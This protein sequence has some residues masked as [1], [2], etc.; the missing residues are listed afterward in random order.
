M[1]KCQSKASFKSRSLAKPGNSM[2]GHGCLRS[3]AARVCFNPQAWR[4]AEVQR[5][6]MTAVH[7]GLF[8]LGWLIGKRDFYLQELKTKGKSFGK[9]TGRGVVFFWGD[10]SFTKLRN[11]HC[12]RLAP[13]ASLDHCC[14]AE[15]VLCEPAR[16]FDPRHWHPASCV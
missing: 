2:H 10:R 5:Q 3:F 16:S 11:R 13:W 6:G 12:K 14:K 1:K 8:F 9:R 7:L 4:P 15:F